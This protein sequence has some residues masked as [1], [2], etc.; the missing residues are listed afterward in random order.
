MLEDEK[1]FHSCHFAIGS[2]YDNDA[3]AMIHLDCLVRNP[4]I[5]VIYP[6]GSDAYIEKDGMLS[7][8]LEAIQ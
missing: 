2:N 5:R 7:P 3:E 1:A 8:S 4:T 6:D